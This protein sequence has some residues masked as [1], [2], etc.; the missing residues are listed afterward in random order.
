MAA[1]ATATA[2]Q[3]LGSL[4]TPRV[5]AGAIGFGESE[6]GGSRERARAPGDLPFLRV[7]ARLIIEVRFFV[8]AK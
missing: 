8:A 2:S 7:S 1:R 3:H 6:V 4:S 5:G